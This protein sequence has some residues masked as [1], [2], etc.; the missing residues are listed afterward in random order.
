MYFLNLPT[1]GVSPG[2][3]P[4]MLWM[5]EH[6]TNLINKKMGS[7][8]QHSHH[9]KEVPPTMGCQ[10]RLCGEARHYLHLA[11]TEEG[12]QQRA[13]DGNREE[14]AALLSPSE[15]K[16]VRTSNE[17]DQNSEQRR[18]WETLYVQLRQT[19]IFSE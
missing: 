11:G 19:G 3:W 14:M 10:Q 18:C 1:E 7:W 2:G 8:N 5:N 17:A 16:K 6:F 9:G 4:M 15:Q 13:G 12:S